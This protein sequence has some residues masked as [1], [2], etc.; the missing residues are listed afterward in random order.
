M[1]LCR[2][3]SSVSGEASK[4]TWGEKALNIRSLTSLSPLATL[5]ERAG[6]GDLTVDPAGEKTEP[7]T[8]VLGGVTVPDS[9]GDWALGWVGR[10]VVEAK[11][12]ESEALERR[13]ERLVTDFKG[14]LAG[15]V[16]GKVMFD[17]ESE[18]CG[19][20]SGSSSVA[21]IREACYSA[22]ACAVGGPMEHR[23][24][25]EFFCAVDEDSIVVLSEMSSKK[26]PSN[27][28]LRMKTRSSVSDKVR[29]INLAA[30]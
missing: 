25:Y 12:L 29:H 30:S 28:G 4:E 2:I 24:P 16:L 8:A 18:S 1:P 21:C 7:L 17:S 22:E 10:D 23:C 20:C 15:L 6:E 19:D 27:V 11:R 26:S 14:D 9:L 3:N 5:A 13:Y